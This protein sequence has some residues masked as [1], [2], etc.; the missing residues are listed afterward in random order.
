MSAPIV[1]IDRSRIRP[2]RVEEVRRKVGALVELI[3][4]R[5]PQLLLYEFAIDDASSR[6][7]VLAI[8]PDPASVELHME[9]GGAAFREFADL[10]DMEGIE[11]YGDTSDRML[12][13]LDRKARDLGE[14][15]TVT[16]RPVDVGFSRLAAMRLGQS[17]E[18]TAVP[19]R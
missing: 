18:S 6:M 17:S 16:V 14:A 11:V 12:E 7:T 4:E 19:D 9:V 2:G 8:H 3:E 5:E 10:L 1:Y 13:E 15:G